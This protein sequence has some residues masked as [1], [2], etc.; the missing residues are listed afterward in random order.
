MTTT[1]T[2]APT[3]DTPL[4]EAVVAEQPPAKLSLY[5]FKALLEQLDAL[6]EA[7][8]LDEAAIDELARQYLEAS[9]FATEAIER[10]CFVIQKREKR[11]A[12]RDAEA[13]TQNAIARG[14]RSLANRDESVIKRLKTSILLFM[15]E[16]GIK[17]IETDHFEVRQQKNSSASFRVNEENMPS[18][19]EL[20][21]HF[22]DL[23]SVVLDETK[24]KAFLEAQKATEL[25][26]PDGRVLA[27]LTKGNHLRLKPSAMPQ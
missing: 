6:M 27:S 15:N 14:L 22:A 19:E 13:K 20:V 16:R 21:Q 9:K 11:F 8:E 2:P 10:Y 24:V 25:L 18:D 4:V 12:V 1:Q 3:P 17:K 7:E 23:C 5:E 26:L